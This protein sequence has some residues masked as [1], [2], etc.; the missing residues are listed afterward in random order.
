[1][2]FFLDFKPQYL[3]VII[4]TIFLL[5]SDFLKNMRGGDI[6]TPK[7]W[8]LPIVVLSV[9][10]V[11]LFSGVLNDQSANYSIGPKVVQSPSQ[12]NTAQVTS[13]PKAKAKVRNDVLVVTAR[14]SCGLY[15][16]YKL[17]DPSW[18]NYCPQCH[19][20][21]ALIFERTSDCPEGMIRCT[22]CDADFCAV[23]GKEHV[24]SHSTYLM[25]A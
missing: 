16:D 6:I 11:G 10:T 25:P 14:C 7:Q 20:H 13:E 8:F 17:H 5:Q 23:H 4:I 19:Q 12:A 9:A 1:M 22:C 24:C 18:I 3:N 15:G 2:S 21:G